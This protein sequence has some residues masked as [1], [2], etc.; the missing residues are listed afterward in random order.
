MSE[1][2]CHLCNEMH[3]DSEEPSRKHLENTITYLKHLRETDRK[4]LVEIYKYYGELE[5]KFNQLLGVQNKHVDT[6]LNL[7]YQREVKEKGVTFEPV[8]RIKQ[9]ELLAFQTVNCEGGKGT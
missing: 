9:V 5:R 8:N 7:I 6:S 1:N 2:W 3:K 4:S